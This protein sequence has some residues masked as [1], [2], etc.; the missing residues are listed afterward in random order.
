M[1]DKAPARGKIRAGVVLLAVMRVPTPVHAFLITGLLH[2]G[3]ALLADERPYDLP[4]REASYAVNKAFVH[5]SLALF[6]LF[7]AAAYWLA[8]RRVFR[9][10]LVQAHYFLMICVSLLYVGSSLLFAAQSAGLMRMV[11]VLG[12]LAF[13]SGAAVFVF[14]VAA[15]ILRTLRSGGHDGRAE[16]PGPMVD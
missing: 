15:G 3:L 6:Y 2:I 16:P 4:F 14:N 12:V 1:P 8:G 10:W 13:L 7:F 11:V 5:G 9:L